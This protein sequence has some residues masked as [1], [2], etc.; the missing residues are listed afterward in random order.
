MKKGKSDSS[1][2]SAST[3][4]LTARLAQLSI[5]S[6]TINT[7]LSR[8]RNARNMDAEKS[9]DDASSMITAKSA[10]YEDT[11]IDR[12]GEI[13]EIGDRVRVLTK[14]RIK[15]THG[16]VVQYGKLITIEA[17]DGMRIQR[18]STNVAKY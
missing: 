3:A 11:R 2:E 1:L 8:R 5:E 14:G 15:V 16:T 9:D 13:L 12:N 6:H 17:S 10:I 4:E 7:I 18:K